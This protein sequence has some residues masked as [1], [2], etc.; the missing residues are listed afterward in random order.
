MGAHHHRGAGEKLDVSEAAL[1]GIRLQAQM[2]EGLIEFIESSV[3]TLANRI[4]GRID[5]RARPTA[6][7]DA[8]RVR[9]EDPDGAR[10][11]GDALARARAAAG[12]DQPVLDRFEPRSA[13]AARHE[14]GCGSRAGRCALLDR[15]LHQFAK[16]GFVKKPSRAS[17]PARFL[18]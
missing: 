12:A 13:V 15:C 11:T 9:R 10:M 17:R 1:T 8:A 7:R 5:G 4:A 16:S 2:Y 18:L 14:M 3:F 6:G